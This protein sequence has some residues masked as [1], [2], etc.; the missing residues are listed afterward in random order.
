MEQKIISVTGRSG[1]GKT[2]LIEKMIVH[3][4]SLGKKVSFFLQKKH[5]PNYHLCYG[6]QH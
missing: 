2:T 4:K 1:S 6:K 3:Y 5:E